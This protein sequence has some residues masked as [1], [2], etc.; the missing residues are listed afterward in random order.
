M[1]SIDK[2]L[3]KRLQILYVE[4]DVVVRN[5]LEQLLSGFFSKVF[6]AGDGREGLE[7]FQENKDDIDIIL[8]D[9]NM[10]LLNGIE[11]VK[12]IRD[13]AA[14]IPVFITTAHSDSEFLSE[15]I[16]LKVQDYIVKPVDIRDL[17]KKMN[18]LANSMY[19]DSMI[20]Q[21]TKELEQYK[22]IIDSNNI[23]VKTDI[24]M[25]ITYVNDLFCQIT[26]YDKDELLGEEFKILK[27][28]DSSNDIYTNMYAKV[29]NNKPWHGVLKNITKEHGIFTTDAYV[30][31]TLDD[32]GEITG[33]ISIQRDITDEVNKKRDIQLA[34]MKD[35]SD[36]FIRSKEGSAEQNIIIRELKEQLENI[37]NDLKK[38]EINS[39]KYIYS[40]EKYTV[41]NRQL[42]SELAAY[43]KNL[44]RKDLALKVS[45][46]NADLKYQ[47]KKL[48]EELFETKEIKAK[49]IKQLNVNYKIEI[50]D[51]EEELR[52]ITEKY[53]S[54]ESDEVLIQKLDYWKEKAQEEATRVE[55]LE[56]QIV[57][58]GDKAF[59]SKIFG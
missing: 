51:L 8:T 35:K 13:E 21:Q 56:K 5:E 55:N 40:I 29:L 52:N 33:T 2:K 7:I 42:R 39:E 28:P 44:S 54:V 58:H 24:H 30:I 26:G 10:P 12:Y 27:H 1:S 18:E 45:K 46:E 41:E 50:E 36:I 57:A 17:L 34:L 11:M 23:V 37:K 6:T 47:L 4:D 38:S 15:S 20:E 31:N 49:E 22:E 3:L 32:D 16:K 59:M 9:I 14:N 25:N 19:Q 43:K 48:K 53:E